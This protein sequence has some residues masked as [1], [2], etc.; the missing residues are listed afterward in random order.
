M[1]S[2]PQRL[3]VRPPPPPPPSN[4]HLASASLR[5]L[6]GCRTVSVSCS[7][8]SPAVSS[9]SAVCLLTLTSV[10]LQRSSLRLLK[11]ITTHLMI[12]FCSYNPNMRSEQR[13]EFSC[14]ARNLQDSSHVLKVLYVR[15]VHLLNPR[16]RRRG[17][18]PSFFSCLS[19]RHAAEGRR[20]DW[21]PQRGHGLC[22]GMS[23]PGQPIMYIIKIL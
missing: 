3:P 1:S 16:R 9:V 17:S 11:L 4:N 6:S 23:A 2:G 5:L 10:T 8:Y 13:T 21:N 14:S 19:G 20:S 7:H 18:L 15:T 12:H 22:R